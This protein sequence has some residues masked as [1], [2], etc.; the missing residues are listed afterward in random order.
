[1]KTSDAIRAETDQTIESLK[2]QFQKENIL[3]KDLT[4]T[5]DN[6][7]TVT[8]VD[9]SKASDFLKIMTDVHPEWM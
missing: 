3:F 9:P 2:A 7:F 4:R 1:V 5:Q 6:R 8:G